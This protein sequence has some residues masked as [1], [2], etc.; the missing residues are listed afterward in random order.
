M[1]AEHHFSFFPNE[2][3]FSYEIGVSGSEG[4]I[5][6]YR[7]MLARELL[8]KNRDVSVH[9]MSTRPAYLLRDE[10]LHGSTQREA[11]EHSFGALS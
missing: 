5:L 4:D 11:W 1:N 10:M 3:A 9:H 6:D 8:K 2:Y 7:A